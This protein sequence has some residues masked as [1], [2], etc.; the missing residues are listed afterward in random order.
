MSYS[1]VNYYY[2]NMQDFRA[3]NIIEK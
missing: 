2:N 3:I 1:P